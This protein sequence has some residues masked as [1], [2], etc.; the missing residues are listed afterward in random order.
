MPRTGG[1]ASRGDAAK[2]TFYFLRLN[3]K[4]AP[5]RDF[6]THECRKNLRSTL[7]RSG[8][9]APAPGGLRFKRIFR[10][11]MLRITASHVLA[12]LHVRSSPEARQIASDLHGSLRG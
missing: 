4:E 10:P 2:C 9:G 1:M 5:R 7:T 11:I 6:F 12:H 3:Q 8:P